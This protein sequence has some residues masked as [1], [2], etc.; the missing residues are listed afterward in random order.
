[1]D[2]A[3]AE[4]ICVSSCDHSLWSYLRMVFWILKYKRLLIDLMQVLVSIKQ[5]S[6]DSSEDTSWGEQHFRQ[7]SIDPVMAHY[8][9]VHENK[10]TY[11]SLNV[12]GALRCF[13]A[14]GKQWLSL[15]TAERHSNITLSLPPK[16]CCCF[17]GLGKFNVRGEYRDRQEKE[18][19]GYGK[20]N[21]EIEESRFFIYL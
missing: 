11:I 2:L 15:K 5:G 18:I 1:M 17:K 4:D 10:L 21:S 16:S 14:S 13:L 19:S 6:F 8:Y 12:R 3:L 7:T 9:S 20:K